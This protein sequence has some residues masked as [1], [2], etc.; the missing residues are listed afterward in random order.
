MKSNYIRWVPAA[1]LLLLGTALVWRD[2][3]PP[4]LHSELAVAE[5]MRLPVLEGGRIKP[6]DT[7]AR[8]NLLVLS[9]RQSYKN[10]EG[11]SVD[12]SEWLAELLLDPG[13]AVDRPVF[14]I[15]HPDLVGLIGFQNEERKYFSFAE[16]GPHLHTIQ[17]QYQL[18]NPEPQ[19]R[20]TFE[21]A[22]VK[23]YEA[24]VLYD[25]TA[26]AVIMPPL[27]AGPVEDIVTRDRILNDLNTPDLAEPEATTV[28][29]AWDLLQSHYARHSESRLLTIYPEEE[30]GEW[31]TLKEV[32]L[33]PDSRADQPH[34]WA[35]LAAAYRANEAE[36]VEAAITRL[37]QMAETR[38]GDEELEGRAFEFFFNQ[39]GPFVTAME[40]YVLVFL[41]AL[42][43]WLFF[44]RAFHLTALI[45]LVLA[46]AV[47]SFGMLARMEIQGRPPVTNLYSSA[48]FV[49]W[50]A[51]LLSI[52]LEAVLRNGVASAAAAI[53]AFPSLII[54][55][56]LSF[57]GD[58][59]EMMRAVLD[60]NF[61]LATHVIVVTFGY[62]ATFLAGVLA[63]IYLVL[64]RIIGNQTM[65]TLRVIDG[66]VYAIVCFALLFSFVG[67]ILGG[68][69]ADQSWGRFWG[70]DPKE[71]GALMIVLWNALFLHARW[72]KV[73]D[74]RGLMQ[75]AIVGNIITAW[76]W[77]GT[78]LLGVGLHSYGFTDSGFRWLVIFAISQVVLLA[79]GFLPKRPTRPALKTTS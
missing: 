72:G 75:I 11:E 79:C 67:T 76:S 34:A 24:I 54:A 36:A 52:L 13:K 25:S 1:I 51:A 50:G 12:A 64:D 9:Q 15:D 21:K 14:R 7:V 17:D 46:F 33:D 31:R 71:N 2:V 78:N 41:A 49:G 4:R 18:V 65:A 48:I 22:V 30:G 58:T 62:S 35:E 5:M 6:L 77:F 29:R 59:L 16:I 73:V 38:L 45:L 27:F 55:H 10:P 68:I 53:I 26:S 43:G 61:W 8:S 32:L 28:A 19:L 20:S 37:E 40:L 60:S 69:W 70:W 66:M 44:P 42:L 56:H 3:Q 47:H 57:S 63:I 23:L 39:F 74:R